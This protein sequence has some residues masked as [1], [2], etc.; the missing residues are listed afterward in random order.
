MNDILEMRQTSCAICETYNNADEVYVANFDGSVFNSSVFSARRLPDRTHYRIVK[1]KSC[2]L[3]RSDPVIGSRV[4]GRL[5]A[6]S[7][8]TYDQEIGNLRSTYGRYLT[9]IIQYHPSQG[10]LLEIGCG[11]G[12][13]LSE[14]LDRGYQQVRGVEPSNDAISKAPKHLKPYIIEE[15]FRSGLFPKN[16]FDVICLFQVFDHISDPNQLLLE[17]NNILKPGGVCFALNHNSMA[18]S[19]RI[20]GA[21]SPIIDIE[22][23][24]LY[25]PETFF[26]I[27]EKNGFAIIEQGPVVNTYSLSY[28]LHLL[29]LPPQ[30]KQLLSKVLRKTRCDLVTMDLLLGNQYLVA[31][32]HPQGS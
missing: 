25:D 3:L 9:K 2:G 5:Y 22:H 21:R 7:K 31:K 30:I 20:L 28:Y 24:Y 27:F 18:L 8:Q 26:K 23:T 19:A 4:L 29:P 1:C 11:S 12:F 17:C 15:M 10:S 32:K 6:E 14:A 13:F 16:H